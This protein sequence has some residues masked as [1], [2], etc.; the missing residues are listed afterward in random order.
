M[1]LSYLK[2]KIHQCISQINNQKHLELIYGLV[3]T[4]SEKERAGE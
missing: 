2:K 4:L 1:K 3:R